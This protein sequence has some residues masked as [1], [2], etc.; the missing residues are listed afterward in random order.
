MAA[1]DDRRSD[2]QSSSEAEAEAEAEA[3]VN[4]LL[5]LD[6]N[7]SAPFQH[8]AIHKLDLFQCNL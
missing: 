8:Y 7:I 2:G 3:E 6:K 4:Q 1:D 5:A